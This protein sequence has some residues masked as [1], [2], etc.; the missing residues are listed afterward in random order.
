MQHPELL[1]VLRAHL[2]P[3]LI[4]FLSSPPQSTLTSSTTFAYSFPLTLRLTRVVFLLLKQFSDLL[5]LEAEIFLTMF[6]RIVGPG[7]RGE[8]E[9]GHPAGPAAA[10]Q[11]SPLW[12]RV[13]ALEI[14]RGLCSDFPLMI[15][16][17]QRY[18][19]AT[20]EAEQRTKDVK[21]KGKAAD[22]GST[23]FGDLVTAL[24]RLASEKPAALGTGSAV[25]YGSSQGPIAS[26]AVHG[27]GSS[28][29]VSHTSSTTGMTGS[30]VID[31]AM[32]MGLGLAQAAGSVV[33]SG[34]AAAAGAVSTA[35]APVPS[36]SLESASMKLQCIDQLDK[37]EP[38]T[39]PDTYLFLLSLQ[40]LTALAD[41]FAGYALHAYSKLVP[42]QAKEQGSAP[43]AL[44]FAILD[45]RD[46]T[47]ASMLVVRAMAESA[48]PALL[49]SM[50]FFIGTSLSDDLF[51]DVVMSIQNFTSVL[52]ILD[53]ET[54]REAFLTS[55]CRFAMPPAIVSYI[56]SH[57]DSVQ[58]SQQ[59]RSGGAVA[60]AT[61]V[62]SAGAESLALLTGAGSSAAPVGLSSRNLACLRALLS[63]AHFLAG[64]LG[65]SWF[66]VFETLQNADVVLRATA[67][68]RGA[69]KR[70]ATPATSAANAKSASAGQTGG[71]NSSGAVTTSIPV[72]PTEEDELAIQQAIADMFSIS[73]ALGDAAFRKF[74][75][76]LCRL[77]G[78]MVGVSMHQDGTLVLDDGA[79]D[80]SEAG[81]AG[82]VTPHHET[83]ERL[84]RRS[85]GMHTARGHSSAKQGKEKSFALAKLGVVAGHNMTR[86]ISQPPEVGWDLITS[87][88]LYLLHESTVP[89]TIRVQSTEVLTHTL[90]GALKALAGAGASDVDRQA[91][92]QQLV[93]SALAELAEPPRRLQT[94][95][96]LE[97]RRM[98]LETLLRIL[99]TS[100]HAL[101]TGWDR[102]F[103]ILRTACPSGHSFLPPI[104]SPSIAGRFSLDT[105]SERESLAPTTPV[106]ASSSTGGY[107]MQPP[108]QASAETS[109]RVLKGAAL[110]RTSFPSLQLI[111]TDFLD[112]LAIDELRDCVATLADFGAQGE[113]VNVALTVSLARSFP[114][115]TRANLVRYLQAGGLLWNVS[116]HVQAKQRD[117]D[118][119]AAH[120]DL[121]MYLLQSMLAHCRDPRQ[122]VRDAAIA[123]VYR[124]LSVYG[125][126]LDASTWE[127]C[128]WEIVFPL[129]DDLTTTI[130]QH[131]GMSDE[132]LDEQQT[133][134]QANGPP[135][136][137]IDK[138]WD[139]SKSLALRSTGEVF[140][141]N[142]ALLA[143][144]ERYE[145]IWDGLLQRFQD[146][147]C[148]DRAGPTTAAMQAFEKVLTVALD[149]SNADRITSSWERAWQA[150]DAIGAE[151]ELNE[152]DVENAQAKAYTQANLEVFVRVALS[153][154]TPPYIHFDLDRVRR[155][156]AVLKAA[157]LYSHSPD[158]RL[159]I[160]GL[161]P[162]QAVVLEVV[163]AIKLGDLGGAPAA[164][165]TELA[166]YAT[167]AY[168]SS[169]EA[170]QYGTFGKAGQRVTYIALAKEVMPHIHYLLNKY[171]DDVAVY[172]EGAV[173][174]VLD[175]S[176][177][178]I[179]LLWVQG[180]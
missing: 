62:L 170:P 173:E 36:L 63:V 133:V 7:D 114:L 47:V 138:Q 39:I 122:E 65:L 32:G 159:D 99:E 125:S 57:A 147:F 21:G 123:N 105:I 27:T 79:D 139:D 40:C 70:A 172:M 92:V 104:P 28:Q 75:G 124:S 23:F 118:S 167:L 103:H 180:N 171:R 88:C 37:A 2:C 100:G 73:Q 33:G 12:M 50:S 132:E 95:T 111:C 87:H 177:R 168:T 107:F 1:L 129:L 84:K 54:P 106:R 175:V 137:L 24:N 113:D 164:V 30:T 90:L 20:R 6:V 16:F 119:P 157:L 64:S 74:V 35:V 150:W 165:I 155:L 43:P 143:Q 69:R 31:S 72:I 120:G 93:F 144:T 55:L 158:Y 9:G 110:V 10:G 17:Y 149:T 80:Q 83:P 130:R 136:R 18:D 151:L 51:S 89:P 38:P 41:G 121:W 141:D 117:G 166:D 34:V 49:A 3:L 176:C 96:D 52:G 154:Y 5:T 82:T 174:R 134:P 15:K 135:L 161:M 76:A 131:D 156:L 11:N 85:S 102:I 78:E 14:F 26:G 19:A 48:W 127:S 42:R 29:T 44:D 86:L 56:T 169:F 153:I 81:S 66:S 59:A 112:A 148:T 115:A 71:S 160:D 97:I 178:S 94:A 53:L 68:G 126:T 91:R 116:D 145:A 77:S 163:A 8:G 179:R 140:F 109:A 25:L 152:Q 142:L 162:L 101:V 61:A 22:G 4:R 108:T 58:A 45:R 98:A 60:A 146:S 67:T 46:P 128:C 13:L